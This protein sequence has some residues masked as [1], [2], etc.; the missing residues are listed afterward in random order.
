MPYSQIA[1]SWLDVA[2]KRIIDKNVTFQGHGS[3]AFEKMVSSF[4]L[5]PDILANIV[6]ASDKEWSEEDIDKLLH[7]V[8]VL[9]GRPKKS[10]A[11]GH[12]SMGILDQQGMVSVLREL[13]K[14]IDAICFTVDSKRKFGLSF[15]ECTLAK[16][17]KLS[18]RNSVDD[19][20]SLLTAMPGRAGSKWIKQIIS[21]TNSVEDLVREAEKQ[22]LEMK[23][24]EFKTKTNIPRKTYQQYSYLE[25][26]D[27]LRDVKGNI[28]IDMKP[29]ATKFKPRN[30][31]ELAFNLC[32]NFFEKS[33]IVFVKFR[34]DRKRHD[35][36][37]KSSV[38]NLVFIQFKYIDSHCYENFGMHLDEL[39]TA[40]TEALLRL[41][42]KNIP[43]LDEYFHENPVSIDPLSK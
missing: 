9:N 15:E 12:K 6:S 3:V 16:A 19:V 36:K 37:E 26:I 1:S 23:K 7:Q 5:T 24:T 11:N 20:V 13:V 30:I 28:L 25:L 34:A 32:D 21:R 18:R 14:Q 31:H 17:L 38:R 43:S 39:P 40:D 8:F 4:G 29:K 27:K 42:L 22:K 10:Q 2:R 35:A 33:E 41:C